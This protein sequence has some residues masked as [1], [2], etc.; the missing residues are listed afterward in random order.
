[1]DGK[2]HHARPLAGLAPRLRCLEHSLLWLRR[3]QHCVPT[4]SGRGKAPDAPAHRHHPRSPPTRKADRSR[5]EAAATRWPS[6]LL[7]RPLVALTTVDSIDEL[8]VPIQEAAAELSL[9]TYTLDTFA[10]WTPRTS[11]HL[12]IAV[13]FGLFVP[14]R[15]LSRATFGGLNVHPSLLPDLKG[16]APIQHA[17]WKRRPYTGVSIQT[18][19]PHHFDQGI[20]LAQTSAPGIEIPS[21]M[22]AEHLESRLATAGA[23]ML[24]HV[25]QSRKYAPPLQ[26]VGWYTHSNGPTEY[27][28]KITK[29]DRFIDFR[30]SKL[31]DILAVQDALGD[32]WCL[33]PDG[34]RVILHSVVDSGH[35]DPTTHHAPGIW[36]EEQDHC[37]VIRD[38][39][40][41]IGVI[42]ES[43]I[44]GGRRRNG[45]AALVQ[46]LAKKQLPGLQIKKQCK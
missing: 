32:P 33:L 21:R 34:E 28:P 27:A 45:N 39:N 11:F 38:V 4:R 30:T 44:A 41:Q 43:T 46:K 25:L 29:Q 24:I 1:M 42:M 15:L 17:I 18:L 7:T 40:G 37:P 10:G 13:S 5:L 14:P 22:T 35:I 12:I 36:I 9:P 26:D 23:D 3:L 2:L 6:S 8:L 20:I 31:T 19:H 16:P